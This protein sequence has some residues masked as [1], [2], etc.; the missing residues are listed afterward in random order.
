MRRFLRLVGIALILV[1]IV[2]VLQGVGI[3]RGSMMSGRP[4]YSWL[5]LGVG[6][7]GVVILLSGSR[8]SSVG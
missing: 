1:G 2:W 8:R 5:G 6:V 3:L 7:V 4:L